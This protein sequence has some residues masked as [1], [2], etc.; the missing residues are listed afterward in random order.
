MSKPKKPTMNEM[1]NVVNNVIREVGNIYRILKGIDTTLS[2]YV[3]F[4]N[5]KEVFT[6]FLEDKL[7]KAK[8]EN[9][10][11]DTIPGSVKENQSS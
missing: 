2:Q 7:K 3:E 11:P 6:K 10:E 5:D 8:E 1:K 4:K 9:G